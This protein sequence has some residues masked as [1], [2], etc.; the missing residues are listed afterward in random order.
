[1]LGT[2]RSLLSSLSLG[3]SPVDGGHRPHAELGGEVLRQAGTLYWL[4][5]VS[6]SEMTTITKNLRIIPNLATAI[7]ITIKS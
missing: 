4:S 2:S 6:T 5:I 7:A 1:M 3:E